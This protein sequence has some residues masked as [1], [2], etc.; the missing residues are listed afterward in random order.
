MLKIL[1]WLPILFKVQNQSADN[2]SQGT[3]YIV[4]PCYLSAF[5]S[6]SSCTTLP[7]LVLWPPGYSC[8]YGSLPPQSLR[9]CSSSLECFPQAS[10]WLAPSLN[11]CSDV[12]FSVRLAL[13][14]TILFKLQPPP[15][16]NSLQGFIFLHCTYN[17]LIYLII[18]L[19]LL[20]AWLL[21]RM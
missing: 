1:Q 12:I 14:I 7:L 6:Y 16:P 19:F 10:T 17:L 3:N 21:F 9:A 8:K 18:Y 15:F 2:S 5:T 13:T 20:C 4:W 11:I